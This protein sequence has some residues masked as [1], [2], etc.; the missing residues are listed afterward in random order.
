MIKNFEKKYGKPD[1]TIFVMGDYDKGENM[2][3]K[4]PTICKKFRRIFRNAG[5]KTYLVNEFR[6]SKLCNFCNGELELF[7]EKPSKSQK[8]REKKS[9]VM[10]YYDVNR[11][12]IKAKYII[13]E[14]KMLCKIC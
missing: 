11:L 5:Y 6:T 1:K 2:K 9:Y 14:I 3:G 12:S 4:E 13:T 10:V 8:E 7:L